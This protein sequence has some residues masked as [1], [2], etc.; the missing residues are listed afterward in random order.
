MKIPK[1]IIAARCVGFFMGMNLY[2]YT[3]RIYEDEF[4]LRERGAPLDVEKPDI[5][6][7]IR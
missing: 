5:L 2:L 4:H 6:M 1:S 7:Y 3:T